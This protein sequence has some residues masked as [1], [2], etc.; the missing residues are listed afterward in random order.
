MKSKDLKY[1]FI[2]F[3]FCGLCRDAQAQKITDRSLLRSRDSLINVISKEADKNKLAHEYFNLARIHLNIGD[4]SQVNGACEKS[5]LY[6]RSSEDY[7]SVLDSYL[8]SGLAFTALDKPIDALSSYLAAKKTLEK[9][10]DAQT[11]G[12]VESQIGLIFFNRFHYQRAAQSFEEA[13]NTYGTKFYDKQTENI[14]YLAVCYYMINSY[15]KAFEKYEILYQRAVQTGDIKERKS[16]LIK[17]SDIALKQNDFNRALKYNLEIKEICSTT[18]ET[19]QTSN[20]LANIAYCYVSMHNYQE[21]VNVF[22]QSI[23]LDQRNGA[24]KNSALAASYTNLGVCYQN[25]NDLPKAIE[26]LSKASEYRLDDKDYCNYSQV[27]NILALIYLKRRDLHNSEV[28]G[29]KAVKAAETC[30]DSQVKGDAYST[31]TRIMQDKGEYDRAFDY[32]KKYLSVT[33]SV[34]LAKALQ[35]RNKAEDLKLLLDA[36]SS[37]SDQL[38]EQEISDL[39]NRQLQLLADARAKEIELLTKNAELHDMEKR[40]IEQ[41]L[42]LARQ[43]KQ[44][45]LNEQKINDLERQRELDESKLKQEE[46]EEREQRRAR[47]LLEEQNQR[48]AADLKTQR[49]EQAKFEYMLAFFGVLFLGLIFWFIIIRNKN[50]KLKEQKNEIETK[51]ADLI[52]KNEEITVQKENLLMANNEIMAINEEITRQKEVIENKNK[53]ITDSIH[54]A[55]RIQEAVCPAPDFLSQYNIDYTLFFRPR[56]IVSGDFYWFYTDDVFLYAVVADCTGHGVPGAF[57]SM[58]GI[59]LLNKIVGERKISNPEEILNELRDGVKS[60][61]HQYTI[62]ESDTKDGMDLS[63]IRL[64]RQTKLLA[65]AGANNNGYVVQSY[66]SDEELSAKTNLDS[67]DL[68]KETPEGF[69]RVRVLRADKMPVGVYTRDTDNFT[70]KTIKLRSGDSVYMSTDGYIDQFGG[71]KG[72]KFLSKNFVE[73]LSELQQFNDIKKRGEVLEERHYQW[74]GDSYK[75]LDDVLVLGITI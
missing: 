33:D 27:N 39:S 58:L 69:V 12:D 71:P 55:K 64:D 16:A 24:T 1:I 43:E 36:E 74:R 62:R 25:L 57:M 59:S 56:D 19:I 67:R 46:A 51:N 34:K 22:R 17:L 63:L 52:L 35:E 61:L 10:P 6:A 48:Q 73:M 41:S 18:G 9:V 53:S 11:Q 2:M 37:F 13:V 8:L 7:Q 60:S 75:Q 30:G 3:V 45:L 20:A 54:Y 66:T 28:C 31:F 38:V 29:T 47:E 49:V 4:Y 14:K 42:R 26:N 40:Q 68:I 23:E 21:A 70:L 72:R 65:F 44:R 50:K 15:D 5:I 32:Y